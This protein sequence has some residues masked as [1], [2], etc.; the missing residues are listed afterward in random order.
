M[1]I[2]QNDFGPI[3][4]RQDQLTTAMKTKFNWHKV[5]RHA[6]R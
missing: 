2:N 4:E 3:S 1:L 5:R 6:G